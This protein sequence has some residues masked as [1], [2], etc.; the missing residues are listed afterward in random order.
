MIH[1]AKQQQ[2]ATALTVTPEYGPPP[3]QATDP[4]SNLPFAPLTDLVDWQAQRIRELFS[5]S[6]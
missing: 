5:A 4:V 2:G 1:Q 3:Y 6:M